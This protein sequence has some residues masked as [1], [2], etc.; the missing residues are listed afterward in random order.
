MNNE[1]LVN[2]GHW[3]RSV[4]LTRSD[5]EKISGAEQSFIG[6]YCRCE[7]LT[8]LDILPN[9]VLHAID[10]N[11]LVR[12]AEDKNAQPALLDRLADSYWA[13]VRS[14]VADNANALIFTL[15]KLA[16]DVDSD[17]RYQLAENHKTPSQVLQILQ[18][19]ENP[20]VSYRADLTMCRL[21]S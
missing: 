18:K 16:Y 19:D 6:E 1:N 20:F 3:S 2:R 13:Q 12:M 14:A 10:P 11:V 17:V 7:N 4:D 21:A 5:A 9:H 8:N 15:L